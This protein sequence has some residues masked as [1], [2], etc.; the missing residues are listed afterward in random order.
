MKSKNN[1]LLPKKLATSILIGLIFIL[2]FALVLTGRIIGR[3]VDAICQ[4]G[5]SKF[6][7]DCPSTLMALLADEK[8]SFQTRNTAIWGLGQL[9]DIRAIPVLK[10]YFTGNIPRQESLDD[11]ISQYE[12]KKAIN[13]LENGFNITAIVWRGRF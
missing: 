1:K 4:V 11:A 13:L 7:G 3:Q 12:L 8:S 2:L 9:G 6:P 5:Q 10:K